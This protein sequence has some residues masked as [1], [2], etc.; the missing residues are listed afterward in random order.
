MILN[1]IDGPLVSVIVPIY[2][3]E[4]FLDTCIQTVISQTYNHWELILVNDGSI[5]SSLNL[6]NQ[7]SE[8][9]SRIKVIN[10]ENTGVS[11]SRNQALDIA[12]GDYV[13]FLDADDY[14]IDSHCL[15]K[16]IYKAVSEN[17]DLVR[18]EYIAVGMKGEKLFSRS[19][20]EHKMKYAYRTLSS[21]EFLCHVMCGEF[22]LFLSLIRRSLLTNI[23]FDT[24]RIFLE[25]MRFYSWVFL[26]EPRCMYLPD[27]RFYAYRK[28]INSVSFSVN[29]KKM[30]DAFDMCNF[31]HERS[32]E[33]ENLLLKD[34]FQKESIS[35]YY[36]TLGT[37]S[38]DMYYDE[39]R[40]YIKK[41]LLKQKRKLVFSWIK[42]YG[43]IGRSVIYYV[44]PY[45]GVL[46]FRL[47]YKLAKLK[48]RIL[49]C[50]KFR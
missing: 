33:T 49:T 8:K 15:E 50:L 13:I 5:D 16:M 7:Y 27:L 4:P 40:S 25:D 10:K 20:P 26:K 42:K 43:Y 2:N 41:L 31:F 24:D 18:G 38:E 34:F 35:M 14:W 9:D 17:L 39:A 22:F 19:V 46:L 45:Q 47:K 48:N 11:D 44:N 30:E 32:L 6:C 23:R 37:L 12:N 3:A 28:N 29:P 36:Y 21:A 1:Y